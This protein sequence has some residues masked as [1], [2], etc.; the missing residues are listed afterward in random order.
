MKLGQIIYAYRQE[1]GISQRAFAREAGLSAGY[2]SMLETDRNPT[3]GRA[4]SPTLDVLQAISDTIG[5]RVEELLLLMVQEKGENYL[6]VT[7]REKRLVFTF[8]TADDRTKEEAEKI[9][10]RQDRTGWMA[11]NR[12]DSSG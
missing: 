1:H 10:S 9:L 7:Q 12:L 3:S 6:A 11:E 5:I 8:R 2:I 4:I